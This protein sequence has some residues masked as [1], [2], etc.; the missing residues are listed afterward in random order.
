M[1]PGRVLPSMPISDH[2]VT[3]VER[4]IVPLPIP[5]DAE[6][7]LPYEVEKYEANGYGRWEWGP[8]APCERRTDLL[9]PAASASAS[10]SPVRLLRFFTITDV[11]ITDK[12]SPAQ[13]ILIGYQG[14]SPLA[15][16]AYSMVMLFT[17]HVLDAIVQTINALHE[18]DAFDFGIGLGDAA[19]STQ[20]NELRWYIDVLDGTPISPRSGRGEDDPD[21]LVDYLRDFQPAGLD[22]CID[23]YQAI[24]NHDQFWMGV[25]PADDHL[26]EVLAGA[27]ILDLGDI[28]S[29]PAGMDSRGLYM[30]SLDC[31][32][33]IPQ[34]IGVGPESAF[35]APPQIAGA[36]PRRRSLTKSEWIGEFLVSTSN[37]R[38]HG[39]DET[40]AEEQF[41]CYSFVPKSDVPIKVIVFDDTQSIHDENVVGLGGYGHGSL[42]R[43]HLEWLVAELDAGQA[44]GQLM[45]VAAHIPIATDAPGGP[46]W[47][48]TVSEVTERELIDTL[49]RYPNLILWVAGHRHLNVVTPLPTPDPARPELG[50]FEVETFSLRDFPQQFRTFDLQ[51]NGDGTVSVIA[52]SVDPAVREGSLAARSRDYA[53]A[54]YQ[55]FMTDPTDPHTEG[56]CNVEL[57]IPLSPEM[58][59][60]IDALVP[61]EQA[62]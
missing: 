16:C 21:S 54:S 35:P 56:P 61:R 41:A 53:V 31:S 60:A 2:V 36:D 58:A 40:A 28:F 7:I 46:A 59:T 1:T 62:R 34:V 25:M 49:H 45:I 4:T 14:G 30:G 52:T 48:S 27:D 9:D 11:H 8:G 19:N 13:A 43:E 3:T 23:W 12:Q 24:G 22:P 5:G 18:R 44:A 29:D 55:L 10:P 26:R 15:I 57:V 50:F 6:P 20:Y 32:T 42:D 33:E 47:W 37:P 51:A 39:F 17:T 38:G